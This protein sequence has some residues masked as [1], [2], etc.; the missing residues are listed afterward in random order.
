MLVTRDVAK[1]PAQTKLIADYNKAIAPIASKVIGHING[2]VTRTGN[3]AGESALG[4]LIADAQL[5]DPS[6]V[7]GFAKPVIAFMNPGGIRAD[8][9]AAASKWGE[10]RG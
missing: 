10:A 4:D 2:D 5:N 3:A 8:L 1:D 7:G 6:V 9:T